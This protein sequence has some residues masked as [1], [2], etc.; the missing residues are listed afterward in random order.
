MQKL[1]E[2]YKAVCYGET[3]PEDVEKEV[4]AVVLSPGVPIE[5]PFVQKFAERNI[6]ISGEIELGY[7]MEKG[8]LIAI[9]GTN[10]KTSTTYMI[11]S[12]A[13]EAGL[14]VGLIGTIHNLIGD[15]ILETERTT[16]A[17]VDLQKILRDMKNAGVE[18]VVMEVSSHALDQARVH[19]VEFD[20]GILTNLTQ[21]HLDYHKT[22]DNYLA[23]KKKLF[24]QSKRAVVNADDPHCAGITEGLDIPLTTF[25][26][27]EKA[28]FFASDIEI[29][30]AGAQFAMRTPEGRTSKACV[31][32]P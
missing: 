31:S 19:G 24:L 26:V 32:L 10:G 8:R 29:T 25:G 15:R 1:P 17:S 12:I 22:F 7:Q 16:P 14:K 9:T 20:I 18:L 3:L 23:A 5:S 4:E 6:P 30:T 11:K 27:R 21:D 13:E 2:G 28:D